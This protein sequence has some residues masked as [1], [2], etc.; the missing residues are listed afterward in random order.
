VGA[1][2]VGLGC[3]SGDGATAG[4]DTTAAQK[5]SGGGGADEEGIEADADGGDEDAGSAGSDGTVTPKDTAGS[6]ESDIKFNDFWI[7]YGR[8]WGLTTAPTEP[9]PYD[10][11]LASPVNP[12]TF[13]KAEFGLGA[14][15][16]SQDLGKEKSADRLT[17]LAF[18]PAQT[19]DL[20]CRFGCF[21][22]PGLTHMAVAVGEQK[23]TGNDFQIGVL[24]DALKIYFKFGIVPDIK[25]LQ[26]AANYF[27]YSRQKQCKGTGKCQYEI[28]RVDLV[29]P[30]ASKEVFTIMPP[31]DDP[32]WIENDTTYDGYFRASLDGST[33]LF[34]T[35]TI[36]STKIYAWRDGVLHKLDYICPFK[37]GDQCVGTGSQY[38]DDDPAAIA[39]D[40]KTI[41]VWMIVDR[42]NRLR[43]YEIGG[44]G[45]VKYTDLASVPAGTQNYYDAI[46]ANLQ[47]WQHATVRGQ[48]Q[49]S[50]DGKTVYMLGHS[51]CPGKSTDKPWTDILALPVEK[52]GDGADLTEADLINLTKN[53][54]EVSPLNVRVDGFALSPAGQ[55]IVFNGTPGYD[56]KGNAIKATDLRHKIDRELWVMPIDGSWAKKQVTSEISW[57][58]EMPVLFT[59][60]PV[61]GK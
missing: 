21:L 15:V 55:H 48:P 37:Q 53:P 36:R 22:D 8:S 14:S 47:P 46:C 17:N 61:T 41:L 39:P 30:D 9:L 57:K 19:K 27:F 23:A 52:I 13:T 51:D 20:T 18:N 29:N 2:L 16:F 40:N 50:P 33:V 7:I 12:K 25:H 11:V 56:S 6:G 32:D 38:H 3:S 34:L 1:W 49:F 24:D 44:G 42:W 28:H 35:P 43:R 45:G 54:R 58:S 4:G 59:P 10:L 5:D 60:R 26:F 31:S